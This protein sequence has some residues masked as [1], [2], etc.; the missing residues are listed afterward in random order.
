MEEQMRKIYT[1]TKFKEFM[2]ELTGKMYCGIGSL[3][4]QDSILEYEVIE[5]VMVNGHIIKKAFAV[6]FKKGDS[7]EEC[8]VRCICRLFEFRGMLCRHALTVLINEK[9]Y[10][11]PYKYILRR[12]RKD[13]KRR[14]T[15]VKVTYSDWVSSDEGRRY[16]RMCSAF[17][18]VADLASELEEK[19]SLVLNR[20]SEMKDEV[21]CKKTAPDSFTCTPGPS[22]STKNSTKIRDPLVVRRKCRPSGKR[23]KPKVEEIITKMQKKKK[24]L[25]DVEDGEAGCEVDNDLPKK[26]LSRKEKAENPYDNVYSISS[27]TSDSGYANLQPHFAGFVPIHPM[28]QHQTR[29]MFHQVSPQ[30]QNRGFQVQNLSQVSVPDASVNPPVTRISPP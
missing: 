3:K 19:C 11:L 14:H 16:D 5:D 26:K 4:S 8:D 18:Q 21:L 23:L 22:I 9:I 2:E 25:K 7:E 30:L 1:H 6:W 24:N 27:G 29:D 10:T 28:Q 20:I 15:K 13:V 17:S 12:W